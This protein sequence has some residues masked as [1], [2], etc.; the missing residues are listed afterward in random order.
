MIRGLPV[1]VVDAASAIGQPEASSDGRRF[2][3][4]KI[5][6]RRVALAVDEVIGVRQINHSHLADVPPLLAGTS[7]NVVAIGTLDSELLM[8]LRSGKLVPE[9]TWMAIEP[10][11]SR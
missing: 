2:V 3:S 8:V 5:A 1:P 6:E 11:D 9:T 7:A 10:G 4:L